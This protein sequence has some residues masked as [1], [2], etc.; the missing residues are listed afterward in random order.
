MK[1]FIGFVCLAIALYFGTS[2]LYSVP[3]D[4]WS[5]FLLDMAIAAGLYRLASAILGKYV[6]GIAAVNFV[7][8]VMFQNINHFTLFSLP[9][10]H[11]SYDPLLVACWA[12]ML[13][14]P[15]AEFKIRR[16]KEPL[17]DSLEDVNDVS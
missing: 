14:G 1:R 15:F 9:N 8:I 7:V 17:E 12:F 2:S 16:K 5:M 3:I 10:K 13:L 4:S 11:V 6:L